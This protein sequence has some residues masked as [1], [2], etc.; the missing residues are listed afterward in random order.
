MATE[1]TSNEVV[2]VIP[3]FLYVALVGKRDSGKIDITPPIRRVDPN[4]TLHR[5]VP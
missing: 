1:K 3:S 4:E 5:F 2:T